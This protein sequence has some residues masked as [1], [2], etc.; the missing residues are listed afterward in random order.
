MKQ[1]RRAVPL[2]G[3]L[4]LLLF[5]PVASASEVRLGLGADYWVNR[6]GLFN[7]T[8]AVDG[9]LTRHL[10]LGGR[11]GALVTSLPNTFGIPLDLQFRALLGDSRVYLEAMAGPW[12]LFTSDPVRAHAAFGF[13]LATRSVDVGLEL[14][15]LDPGPIV[16]VRVAF[17]L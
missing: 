14:G 5:P 9:N 12:I 2:L 17:N 8:L 6:L 1:L 16:G 3:T 15:W 7:L 11:A 4:A 13:G 10:S